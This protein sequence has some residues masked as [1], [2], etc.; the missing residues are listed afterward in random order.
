MTDTAIHIALT[1]DDGF[2][3]PAFATMRSI[4]LSSR[5]RA[6]LN[7]H[8]LHKH[9]SAGRRAELDAITQEFPGVTLHDYPI[10]QNPHFAAVKEGF[11]FKWRRLNDMVLARLIFD[12]LLPKSVHR[13]IYLDCDVM[14]R[15]PIE[16]LWETDLAGTS[17]GGVI[18]PNRHKVMLG[19]EFREKTGIFTYHEPYMNGGVL[20]IDLDR[21]AAADLVA[22]TAQFREQGLLEKLYYDQDIINLVFRGDWTPIDF[23]WNLTNALPE[24]EAL[25]PHIVHYSGDRKPWSLIPGT[26]FFGNYRHVMTNEKYYAYMRFRWRRRLLG[27]WRR[28]TLQPRRSRA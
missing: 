4:A 12:R 11:V 17:L 19:R 3:A 13:L 22:R 2:W 27:L 9:L 26:A 28:L 5:R 6:D 20:L 1:F 18:D 21:W 10:A 7:F 15:A 24:H 23:R 25:E 16:A 8:L 14:V